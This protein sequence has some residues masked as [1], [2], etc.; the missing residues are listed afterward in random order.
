LALATVI[1]AGLLGMPARSAASSVQAPAVYHFAVLASY[2]GPFSDVGQAM[3]EGAK[4]GE[5]AVN[6]S[7]GILGHKLV[8]DLVDTIGD[9][10]D[11]VTA[12]NKEIAFNHPI[13]CIGPTTSEIFGVHNI[14][15]RDHLPFMFEGGSTVFD[16]NTD[17]YLWRSNPSDSQLSVAMAAW[18]IKM[19]YKT[20]AL[21]FSVEQSAQTLTVP[22]QR[23]YKK[24]G[25]KVVAV[26]ALSIGQTSYRSEVL[27]V[28][29]ARPRA[30]VI[31]L[32]TEP[33]SAG[34]LFSNFKE[35]NNMAIPFIGTDLTAGSDFIK[36]VT[37]RIAH[38]HIVS[39]VG[40]SAPG[41]GGSVFLQ[42]NAKVW[43]HQPLASA[44]Y[45]YDG[46]VDLALAIDKAGTTN[47]DKIVAAI[48]VVSNPPGKEVI[49]Y[50]QGVAALARGLKI[51]YEG[52]S[53]P[54]DYDK[55]HNVLG[56]FD[57]VQAQND[58]SIKTLYT[59]SAEQLANVIAGKGV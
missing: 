16:N 57:I 18:A 21:M 1:V 36:A 42:F 4:D 15:D 19:H 37:P 55:Y 53:G 28:V 47:P 34:A 2:T 50:A 22:L 29:H 24:N 52:A 43:K 8:V 39:A 13:G 40:S 35:L 23:T 30:Q 20:A 10:A 7:G 38:A 58:G 14:L 59:F 26:V 5:A 56:P 33:T 48:P 6:A 17:K 49:S 51:N 44:N 3:W 46:V 31:F 27:K 25:G 54:T 11:A 45:A 32:Q 12:L 41:G 9:P